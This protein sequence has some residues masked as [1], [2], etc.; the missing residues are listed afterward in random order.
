MSR[1]VRPLTDCER[2][3]R[4]M[5]LTQEEFGAKLGF[6]GSYIRAVENGQ[7][8]LSSTMRFRLLLAESPGSAHQM[9]EEE[10][11][12]YRTELEQILKQWASEP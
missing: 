12:R 2:I 7:R 11:I 8:E 6:S 3:R 9:I 5:G 10:V 1:K 4:N